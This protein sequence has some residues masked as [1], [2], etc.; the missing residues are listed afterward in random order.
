MGRMVIR[1]GRSKRKRTLRSKY[2]LEPTVK[3]NPALAAL[4]AARGFLIVIFMILLMA[5]MEF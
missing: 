5:L 4:V 1:K 3:E 2:T